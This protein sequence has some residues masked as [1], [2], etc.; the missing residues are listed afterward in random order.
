MCS[1]SNILG[2]ARPSRTRGFGGRQT[3]DPE[4]QRPAVPRR[5]D[6]LHSLNS[7]RRWFQRPSSV[8]TAGRRARAP[9]SAR[10]VRERSV[11]AAAPAVNGE[12]G[13]NAAAGAPGGGYPTD[14]GAD[15]QRKQ[16]RSNGAADVHSASNPPTVD[17]EATSKNLEASLS[18]CT[19]H[20]ERIEQARPPT[21]TKCRFQLDC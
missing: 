11:N 21:A 6:P 3:P 10:R 13:A 17:E 12:A 16:Q 15:G 8:E 19:A 20:R 5:G 18:S 14:G 2:G 7:L 9:F 1:M 4:F